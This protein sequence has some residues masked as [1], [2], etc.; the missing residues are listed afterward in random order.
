MASISLYS[1]RRGIGENANGEGE[2]W[3][4]LMACNRMA[5]MLK[6]GAEMGGVRGR[7]KLSSQWWREGQY[8]WVGEMNRT[9]DGE[10]SIT[11]GG[12]AV[13]AQGAGRARWRRDL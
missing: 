1:R 12:E 7:E 8:E 3:A 6:V 13:T 2:R 9:S 10:C 4:P 11:P 5:T